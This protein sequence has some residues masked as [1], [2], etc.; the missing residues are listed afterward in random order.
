MSSKYDPNK[1][2]DAEDPTAV[3]TSL[4]IAADGTSRTIAN[5]MEEEDRKQR[6]K[7]NLI[8]RLFAG[9]PFRVTR[10]EDDN[11]RVYKTV[12][13]TVPTDWRPDL[14]YSARS[15]SSRIIFEA[16]PANR[17]GYFAG[18]LLIKEDD[19]LA[20]PNA[21]PKELRKFFVDE[22]PQF[23]DLVDDDTMASVAKKS[24]SLLPAFRYVGPRLH[25]GDCT[26]ILGDCAHTV[27]PYFGLGANSALE[28]VEVSFLQMDAASTR[29]PNI[30]RSY[31]SRCTVQNVAPQRC[32]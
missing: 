8:R 22:F 20:A 31:S 11:Q 23:N 24:A 3:S 12:P 19:P 28:D 16:L 15:T 1:L 30:V 14:N 18:V 5:V 6:E 9:K 25:Q 32:N 21:D 4:L 17:N 7:M 26:V 27:K 10:Y 29:F 13:F 2:C